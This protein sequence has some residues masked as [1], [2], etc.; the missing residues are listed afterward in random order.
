MDTINKIAYNTGDFLLPEKIKTRLRRVYYRNDYMY[1]NGWSF[2]HFFSGVLTGYLYLKLNYD[3]KLYLYKML[4]IHTIWELWQML[5]GMTKP[6][7]PVGF[8]DFIVDTIMFM[9]GA[10]I[11]K[12][13]ID[14]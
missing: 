7:K 1:L 14:K 2:V 10:I 13:I 11:I 6:Y 4:I 5:I 3:R 12:R 9:L 8:S